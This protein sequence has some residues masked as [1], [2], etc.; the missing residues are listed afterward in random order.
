MAPFYLIAQ[1]MKR[2]GHMAIISVQ[3]LAKRGT[4]RNPPATG[5]PPRHGTGLRA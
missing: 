2:R 3:T 5:T 4:I 1:E